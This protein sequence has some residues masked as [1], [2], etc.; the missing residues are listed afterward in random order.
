MVLVLSGWLV[1]VTGLLGFFL[2]LLYY[3]L[4]SMG[5]NSGFIWFIFGVCLG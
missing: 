4:G 3:I 5:F 1:V 2:L